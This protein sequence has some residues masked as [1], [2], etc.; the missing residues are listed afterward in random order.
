MILIDSGASISV[1][2][3]HFATQ[4]PLEKEDKVRLTSAQGLPIE[5]YWK[6]KVRLRTEAGEVPVTSL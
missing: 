5:V 4:I 1:C 2:P 3:K 6:K